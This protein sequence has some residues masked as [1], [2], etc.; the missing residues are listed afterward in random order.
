MPVA[1]TRANLNWPVWRYEFDVGPG[2]GT[3]TEALTS[4]AYE[5]SFIMDRK[6]AGPA[7]A[8]VYLQDIWARFA[9]NSDAQNAS[10]KPWARYTRWHTSYM[11]FDRN[12]T[13]PK[14]NLRAEQCAFISAI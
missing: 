10:D 12:G 3:S 7:S 13:T 8:P 5:I 4:H 1:L 11:L 14:V 9:R 2:H 6:P